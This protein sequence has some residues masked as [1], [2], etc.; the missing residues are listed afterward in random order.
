MRTVFTRILITFIALAGSLKVEAQLF[1]SFE[2]EA[3]NMFEDQRYYESSLLNER[4]LTGEVAGAEKLAHDR[5]GR[6]PKVKPSDEEYERVVYKLAQ[7][8]RL[9]KNYGAAIDWYAKV[10]DNE[11]Y[12]VAKFYH[13]V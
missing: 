13:A 10:L 7:S 11:E 3:D 4:L 9:Y 5:P 12:P 6:G 8:L 1:R 2:S